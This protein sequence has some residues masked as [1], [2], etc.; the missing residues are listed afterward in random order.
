MYVLSSGFVQWLIPVIGY[1]K[2]WRGM[3]RSPLPEPDSL[4]SSF[5][6]SEESHTSFACAGVDVD[7]SGEQDEDSP[8]VD[9][10]LLELEAA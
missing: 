3:H 6:T 5:S 7:T 8:D 2:K 1:I 4:D 9:Q 10:M